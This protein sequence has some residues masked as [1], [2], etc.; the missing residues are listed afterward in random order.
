MLKRALVAIGAM[1]LIV[2]LIGMTG[3][4]TA[5]KKPRDKANVTIEFDVLSQQFTGT[6]KSSNRCQ[7][8]RRVTVT[9]KPGGLPDG[10]NDRPT[11]V[12]V[13]RTNK[14]GKYKVKLAG[15]P[16]VLTNYRARVKM[17]TKRSY[18][19]QNAVSEREQY[20]PIDL[21]LP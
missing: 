8:V 17:K 11:T 6:V 5:K 1:A 10:G 3:T 4:A 21:P 16:D 18:I 15:L 13:D 14:D 7:R 20:I 9:E 12:G 19:C 2:G